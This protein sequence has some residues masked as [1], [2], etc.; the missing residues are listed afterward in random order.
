MPI[1][2]INYSYS[3]DK[4]RSDIAEFPDEITE[5][6]LDVIQLIAD[7]RDTKGRKLTADEVRVIVLRHR[8]V[9]ANG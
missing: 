2:R 3:V 8:I 1:Q 5:L 4:I 6:K 9:E 7:E